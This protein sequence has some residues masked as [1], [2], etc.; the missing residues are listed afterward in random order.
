MAFTLDELYNLQDRDDESAAE[1]NDAHFEGSG[2]AE[3]EEPAVAESSTP[4]ERPAATITVD[5]S[6][7]VQELRAEVMVLRERLA[8]A[9]ENEGQ[10]DPFQEEMIELLRS[11]V[12]QLQSE[13]TAR[14]QLQ[15]DLTDDSFSLTE[16][17]V[18]SEEL[19][20]LCS[21]LEELL[22]ELDEKDEQV[23]VLQENLQAAEDANHAEQAERYQLESWL[24][25]IESRITRTNRDYEVQLSELQTRLTQTRVERQ[26]AETSAGQHNSDVRVEALQRVVTQVREEK[27]GLQTELDEAHATIRNLESVVEDAKQNVGREESVQLCQERAE[28]ARQRFEVEKLKREMEEQRAVEGSDLRIRALRDHLKEVHATEA[29]EKREAFQNT[30]AGRV[31]RLWKRLD[32]R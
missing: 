18:D 26:Q 1:S 2:S 28:I 4:V 6:N 13:L 14:D 30:L 22:A 25:E 5:T 20:K 11:E 19:S 21:R 23:S 15:Q 16:P 9:Q 27:D 3:V 8:A 7:E 31:S 29:D 12:T 32:N 17:S 10:G 24:E